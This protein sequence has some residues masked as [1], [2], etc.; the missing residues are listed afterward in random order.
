MPL[1]VISFGNLHNN[2]GVS[3]G[4]FAKVKSRTANWMKVLFEQVFFEN[5]RKR[6]WL[7]WLFIVFNKLTPPN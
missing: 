2:Y 6:W 5:S 7:F 1:L 3:G 4:E